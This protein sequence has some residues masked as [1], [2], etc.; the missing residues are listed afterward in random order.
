MPRCPIDPA[1]GCSPKHCSCAELKKPSNIESPVKKQADLTIP[2]DHPISTVYPK[3]TYPIDCCSA[4]PP[5]IEPAPFRLHGPRQDLSQLNVPPVPGLLTRLWK[6]W[7]SS[8]RPRP[9]APPTV[10]LYD[11]PPPK[12]PLPSHS[13]PPPS[14]KKCVPKKCRRRPKC[15]P[16]KCPVHCPPC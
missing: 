12:D 6:D 5:R 16:K 14:P 13:P 1:C 4:E 9:C 11:P 2:R 15:P 8:D 7:I 10:P 3:I